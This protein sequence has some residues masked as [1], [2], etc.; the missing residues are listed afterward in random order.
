MARTPRLANE[1]ASGTVPHRSRGIY[2]LPISGGRVLGFLVDTN[3]VILRLPMTTWPPSA[4]GQYRA[5]LTT[6]ILTRTGSPGRPVSGVNPG[7][8]SSFFSLSRPSESQ[9]LRLC[10]GLHCADVVTLDTEAIIE[11]RWWL[12]QVDRRHGRSTCNSTTDSSWNRLPTTSVGVLDAVPRPQEGR[13]PQRSLCC[14]FTRGNPDDRLAIRTLMPH[15]STY[16]VFLRMDT[17]SAVQYDLRLG[18]P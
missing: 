2:P 7:H 9:S 11:L 12:R 14:T 3:L 5:G 15:T 10:Q 17:V 1:H 8:L 13:G 16:G 4:R 6:G 18:G